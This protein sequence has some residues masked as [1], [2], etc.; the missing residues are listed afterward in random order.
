MGSSGGVIV[1][2]LEGGYKMSEGGSGCR[3][4]RPASEHEIVDGYR[5]GEWLLIPKAQLKGL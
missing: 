5:R 4:D 1:D 3:V 2:L